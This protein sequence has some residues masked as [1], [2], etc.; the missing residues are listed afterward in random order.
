MTDDQLGEPWERFDVLQKHQ[1]LMMDPDRNPWTNTGTS[2]HG[3]LV[4]TGPD[5]QDRT[6]TCPECGRTEGLRI[7][8]LAEVRCPCGADFNDPDVTVPFATALYNV[9]KAVRHPGED[10]VLS[11]REGDKGLEATLAPRT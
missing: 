9:P 5:G 10:Q 6:V 4:I 8:L 2:I 7:T 3:P 1:R 11:L